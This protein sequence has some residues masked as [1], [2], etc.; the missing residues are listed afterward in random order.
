MQTFEKYLNPLHIRLDSIAD[1][2]DFTPESITEK[3]EYPHLQKVTDINI[4]V[5]RKM[6]VV[7]TRKPRPLN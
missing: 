3:E 5:A 6:I 4:E 2:T 1:F 7:K